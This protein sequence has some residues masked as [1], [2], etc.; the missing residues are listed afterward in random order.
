MP[1]MPKAIAMM[2]GMQVEAMASVTGLVAISRPT[3]LAW[4]R[5]QPRRRATETLATRKPQSKQE[6]IEVRDPLAVA[7]RRHRRHDVGGQG[8]AEQVLREL[9]AVAGIPDLLEIGGMQRVD[10]GMAGFAQEERVVDGEGLVEEG[11]Q[12]Q[13]GHED[14]GRR[15]AEGHAG[16]LGLGGSGG[17]GFGVRRCASK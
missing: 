6:L 11:Q 9:L 5:S 17:H 3:V 1:A 14:G 7:E 8:A 13:A 10:E 16:G 2:S 12:Q 15:Q 4:R